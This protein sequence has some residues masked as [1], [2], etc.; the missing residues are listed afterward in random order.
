MKKYLRSRNVWLQ[1]SLVALALV[2]VYSIIGLY[3]AQ[4]K[5]KTP[6]GMPVSAT[7]YPVYDLVRRVGG[8]K[9]NVQL[10]LPEGDGPDVLT[11]LY[12]GVDLSKSRALFAV[13]L[14]YDTAGLPPDQT[15]KLTTLDKDINVLLEQGSVG[16][17]YYW[18]SVRNA[19][20]MTKTIADKLAELDPGSKD[21]Y[22]KQRDIVIEQLSAID[23]EI[24]S[25]L[26][27]VPRKS[28][29]IYGYDW[30]YFA[31]DYGLDIA[32]YEPAGDI[33][34]A[35]VEELRKTMSDNGLIAIFSDIRLSPTAFLPAMSKK[36]FSVYNLDVYGGVED[37]KS[38]DLT[39]AYNAKTIYQ[40]LTGA[41]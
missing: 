30:G 36:Y 2:I 35:R 31:Q 23:T 34:E 24:A 27:K 14:N 3:G 40:G 5:T 18:L 25:L 38:Y 13:G 20:Q 11:S 1:V 7:I 12:N 37:R 10:L 33:S 17:P 16:S 19:E 32:A 39:M 22:M 8:E 6:A 28:L 9:V 29:V 41:P 4:P 26:A 21:Y 15:S